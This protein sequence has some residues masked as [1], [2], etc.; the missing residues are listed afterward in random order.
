M[1]RSK[2]VLPALAVFTVLLALTVVLA[3]AGGSTVAV[4]A[5]AAASKGT[6]GP[7]GPRGP[8]GPRGLRG[9]RGP[10]GAQGE[11]GPAGQTGPAGP[12][13]PAGPSEAVATYNDGPIAVSSPQLNPV[14]TLQVPTPGSYVVTAKGF[15][16]DPNKASKITTCVLDAEGDRDVIQARSLGPDIA[17]TVANFS[18][19]VV[20]T[21]STAMTVTLNCGTN[22]AP[23][24]VDFL[25]IVAIR[26]GHVTN[27][28]G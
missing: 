3:T 21:S 26:V 7:R 11:Q 18:L 5:S 8:Q 10:A 1:S 6:P 24:E 20:H 19:E 17:Q 15:V 4:A 14:L 27:T 2:L 9:L 23:V 28:R 22:G 16:T 12:A 25:K 13:G